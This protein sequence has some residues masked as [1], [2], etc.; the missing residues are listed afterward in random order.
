MFSNRY[1]FI[2]SA[3]M[4]IVVAVALTV[5]AVQLKPR[6][7]YNA[8]VE[9]MQNI[10]TSVNIASTPQNAE[11][12]Y[13]KYIRETFVVNT[14]GEKQSNVNAFDVDLYIELKKKP[15]DRMLPVFVSDNG[16][17]ERYYIVPLRG[18]GLWGPIWGY[19]SFRSDFN[20]VE[21]AMF[22]HKGETPGLGAE[23]DTPEFQA[24]FKGKSIF[25]DQGKFVSIAVVKG[26][27]E[28]SDPHGVDAI[29][30]G[31]ITSQ[32]LESMIRDCLSDYI[33]FF[34]LQ[35]KMNQ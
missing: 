26:G 13:G 7:V 24:Q 31:T 6:Q 12:E 19:I 10:L 25:D 16:S 2:Y 15:V 4:V 5:V 14:R 30:G 9:K 18:K 33:T 11:K 1:I 17:G 35:K 29:S 3:V 27:T 20:T 22:A 32:G 21:G 34:E 28:D 23:I 8:R